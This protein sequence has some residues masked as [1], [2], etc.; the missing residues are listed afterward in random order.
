MLGSELLRTVPAGLEVF[1][2][3]LRREP[4]VDAVGIDLAEPTRVGALFDEHGPFAGV[5]H[6]AA[7]T[8]VDL[9]EERADDA[10]RVNETACATIAAACARADVPL[11]VVGTDFVFDGT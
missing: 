3:D 1:G 4:G 7:W 9:A 6:A 8:A 2:T 11:V 5:I 10:R